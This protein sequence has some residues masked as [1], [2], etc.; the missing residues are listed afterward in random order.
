MDVLL[1]KW[2]WTLCHIDIALKSN[3]KYVYAWFFSH[4]NISDIYYIV[5][6]MLSFFESEIFFGLSAVG[7]GALPSELFLLAKQTN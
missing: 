3:F 5:I 6:D 1:M 7:T 4:N 2:M